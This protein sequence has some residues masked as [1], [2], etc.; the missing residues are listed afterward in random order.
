VEPACREVGHDDE[1]TVDGIGTTAALVDPGADVEALRAEADV[2]T[3][4]VA[5][6]EHLPPVLGGSPL[7]PVADPVMRLDLAERDRPARQEVNR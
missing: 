1:I 2:P 5:S 3:V 7:E 4:P 6:D